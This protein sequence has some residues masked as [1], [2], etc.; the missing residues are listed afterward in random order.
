MFIY[1]ISSTIL[2]SLISFAG[3]I[4]LILKPDKLQKILK[5]LISF[6]AGTMLGSAFIHLLP[7]ASENLSFNT[8]Y[9]VIIIS[10]S[11]LFIIEKLLYWHHCHK[12][13]CKKHTLG[14]LNLIGDSI[15]NFLDGIIIAGAFMIDIK[16][17]I[18]TV[19]A[20]IF[21]EIPQ[22]I[23][24]FGILLYSGFSRK[25]AIISNFVISL[26][27]IL[28]SLFGY[29]LNSYSHT[30]KSYLL[31]LA[32]GNFIYIAASDLLPEMKKEKNM[33]QSFIY[34]IIFLIGNI[35]IYLTKYI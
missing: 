26:T 16:I 12:I 3:V 7:E 5:L 13:Q 20:I 8:I 2:V 33:K 22:E 18:T 11:I 29:F 25:K 23:S 9:L 10:F 19:I 14:S 6:S 28:G 15:H 30:F 24:D 1:I 27:S 34:L 32:A 31:P 35:F 17:G 4:T 21:H